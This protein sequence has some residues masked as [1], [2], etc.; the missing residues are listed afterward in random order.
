MPAASSK[1]D[2]QSD[3]GF[4]DWLVLVLMSLPW[5]EIMGEVWRI[6]R[7]LARG[8][9]DEG[10]YEVL[11]HEAILD[12]KDK[13]GKSAKV[14]KL[15]TVRY[16]QNHIIAFQDQAWG[17][18]DILI[19]YRCK[20][21]K[22]VDRWRPG[23]KTYL[24]ISLQETKHR[25]DTDEFEI[26]WGIR[27]GFLRENELWETEIRHRTKYLKMQVIFPKAR[28][29]KQAWIGEHLSK[30]S[31]PLSEQKFEK[32][33]D[34]RRLATWEKKRPRLNERYQLRWSW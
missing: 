25:G 23:Q 3:S 30:K 2:P 1:E 26:E 18:G 33:P 28:P 32:L 10:I 15:Q 16:L 22:L 6:I 8:M 20:P 4:R 29:P 9:G 21:G 27:N 17:D 12:L 34:G 7:Q 14:R 19:N 31:E 24:L 13:R 5:P 11:S